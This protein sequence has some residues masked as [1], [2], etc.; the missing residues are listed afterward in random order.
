MTRSPAAGMA[1]R[2]SKGSHGPTRTLP[3]PIY[4]SNSQRSKWKGK[5]G[6]TDCGASGE[7]LGSGIPQTHQQPQR[8]PYQ[9]PSGLQTHERDKSL[10]CGGLTAQ[11]RGML[12]GEGEWEW[13][14]GW[15]APP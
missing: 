6:A 11:S 1:G 10:P 7:W 13:V 12:E 15:G 8:D 4:T 9:G 3:H 5:P 14:G 2:M